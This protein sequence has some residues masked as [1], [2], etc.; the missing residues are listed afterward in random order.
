MTGLP[1]MSRSVSGWTTVKIWLRAPQ[2]KSAHLRPCSTYVSSSMIPASSGAKSPAVLVGNMS[3][4]VLSKFGS[5]AQ[6]A[7]AR[8]TDVKY[9]L[10]D[11][12]FPADPTRSMSLM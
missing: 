8:E 9:S 5:H 6:D 12:T 11:P 3:T 4:R 1:S 7:I 10:N 2:W